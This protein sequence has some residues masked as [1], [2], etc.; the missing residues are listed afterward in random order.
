MWLPEDETWRP[1]DVVLVQPGAER[2]P[3]EEELIETLMELAEVT[4]AEPKVGT[5]GGAGSS[6]RWRQGGAC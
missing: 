2:L 4:K 6:A 3:G 1:E 5:Q